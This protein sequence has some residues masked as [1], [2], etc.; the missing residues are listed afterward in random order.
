MWQTIASVCKLLSI[1]EM[2]DKVEALRRQDSQEERKRAGST[3]SGP[4]SRTTSFT[5]G[6]IVLLAIDASDNAKNAF[7]CEY[8]FSASQ[9]WIK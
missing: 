1:A 8:A 7:E 5:A 4:R 6:R 9:Q 2:A 3:G